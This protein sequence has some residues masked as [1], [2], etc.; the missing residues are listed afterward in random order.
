MSHT[1]RWSPICPK[2]QRMQ[3]RA[4]ANRQERFTSLAH[5]LTEEA[6]ARAYRGVRARAAVGIDGQT[7]A[8]YGEATASDFSYRPVTH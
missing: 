1:P 2:L 4:R 7:K 3:E 5:L 8:S 6:L